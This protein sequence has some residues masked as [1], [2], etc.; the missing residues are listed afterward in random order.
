MKCDTEDVLN[1]IKCIVLIGDPEFL[2]VP[3][4][5]LVEW[6]EHLRDLLDIYD[7]LDCVVGF[8][9]ELKYR[10]VHFSVVIQSADARDGGV[11]HYWVNRSAFL[12]IRVVG[13][14]YCFLGVGTPFTEAS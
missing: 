5:D 7:N 13:D 11:D 10:Y 8:S 9:A 14:S 12:K 4:W 3:V 1:L 6:M 2:S